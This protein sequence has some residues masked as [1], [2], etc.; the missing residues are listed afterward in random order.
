MQSSLEET[1]AEAADTAHKAQSDIRNITTEFQGRED[2]LQLQV[3]KL[4]EKAAGCK[5]DCEASRLQIETL[6]ASLKEMQ[7]T[8]LAKSKSFEE[9]Q[10][11]S[12]EEKRALKEEHLRLREEIS[13]ARHVADDEKKKSAAETARVA[14]INSRSKKFRR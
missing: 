6:Q 8:S 5:R 1:R 3:L 11:A 7:E 2:K 12:K 4:T 13:A 10:H 14:G 9:M